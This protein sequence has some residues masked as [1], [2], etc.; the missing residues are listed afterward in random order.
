MNSLRLAVSFSLC[1]F[2]NWASSQTANPSEIPAQVEPAAPAPEP[3]KVEWKPKFQWSGDI[4]YRLVKG[5]ESLDEERTYQQLRARLGARADVNEDV[6]AV[7]RLMTAS[8][9]ISGNQTLG[10]SND[11]GMP[12]R[13]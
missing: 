6:Q 7:L 12:R 2:C 11:P 3:A 4:R 1:F 5:H 8:S 10:D 13:A 9:A